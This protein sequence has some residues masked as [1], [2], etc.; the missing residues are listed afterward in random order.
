MAQ[1]MEDFMFDASQHLNNMKADIEN[2][3]FAAKAFFKGAMNDAETW[4]NIVQDQ[5]RSVTNGAKVSE[6]ISKCLRISLTT[7]LGY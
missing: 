5:F 2:N 7:I 3:A 4:G 1:I 6:K